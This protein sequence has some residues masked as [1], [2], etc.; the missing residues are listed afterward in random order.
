MRRR[1]T[2][3]S[4]KQLAAAL[5]A[6]DS[7]L[8]KSCGPNGPHFL[9]LPPGLSCDPNVAREFLARGFGDPIDL[10]LFGAATAQ[11]WKLKTFHTEYFE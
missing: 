9:V 2:I 6:R 11:T 10:G 5:R 4:C 8:T 7:R 1:Y 3:N